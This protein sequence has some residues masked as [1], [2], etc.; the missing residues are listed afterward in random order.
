MEHATAFLSE[1]HKLTVGILAGG[2]SKRMGQ[3]KA[4]LKLHGE[5][6]LQR[7]IREFSTFEEV[8]I[9]AREKGLYE[10]FGVPVVLDENIWIGPIEGV[11]RIIQKAK[12]PYIFLCAADMPNIKKEHALYLAGYVSSDHDCYAFCDSAH[13]HPLCAIYSKRA[14]PVIEEMISEGNYRMRELLGRLRTKFV[15]LEHTVFSP[16]DLANV[17]TP[18][19]FQSLQKPYVF[20][21]SGFSGSGKTTLI[22]KLIPC[23][24]NIGLSVA[25]LKHDGQDHI[26]DVPGS[27]TQLFF[28][29]GA[30]QSIVYSKTEL[31]A[32]VRLSC[33][34]LDLVKRISASEHKPDVLIL[35]GLKDSSYPKIEVIRKAVSDKPYCDP[36]TLICIVSD[37]IHAASIDSPVFGLDDIECIFER[38]CQYFGF[39]PNTTS[40]EG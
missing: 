14:L 9:S 38:L 2:E 11:R 10:R 33:T 15:T 37:C 24:T 18:E 1:I 3:N 7:S 13:E 34:A 26:N 25:V 28:E 23:F 5:T 30:D 31:L 4:L 17:N 6:L 12:S 16:S 27:D 32:H 35:E 36:F 22:R 20:C 8:L 39:V 21:V 29:A 40:L 19:D